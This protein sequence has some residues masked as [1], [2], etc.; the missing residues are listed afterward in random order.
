VANLTYVQVAEG[1]G[2]RADP[3]NPEALIAEYRQPS[4]QISAAGQLL[5]SSS[6]THD[7]LRYL[8]TYPDGPVYAPITGFF[9]RRYGAT[10]VERAAGSVVNGTDPRLLFQPPV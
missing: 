2:F 8:R 9:S 4:G 3:R 1:P 7:S 5:A 6:P 10:G